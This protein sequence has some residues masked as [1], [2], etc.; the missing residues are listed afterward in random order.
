MRLKLPQQQLSTHTREN[1]PDQSEKN[2]PTPNNCVDHQNCP[3]HLVWLVI[4]LINRDNASFTKLLTSVK[5]MPWFQEVEKYHE[6][7]KKP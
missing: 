5:N 7:G 2:R 1:G 3:F 6:I 4:D